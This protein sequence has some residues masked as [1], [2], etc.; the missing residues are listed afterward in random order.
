MLRFWKVNIFNVIYL[1]RMCDRGFGMSLL[2]HIKKSIIFLYAHNFYLSIYD[3]LD[4]IE[5]IFNRQKR[6]LKYFRNN[7][8]D[9]TIIFFALF[10]TIWRVYR[11]TMWPTMCNNENVKLL[12]LLLNIRN[13]YYVQNEKRCKNHTFL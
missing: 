10:R 1:S 4:I 12:K 7:I 11:F 8:T 13:T 9:V 6:S 5:Y 2:V 3:I